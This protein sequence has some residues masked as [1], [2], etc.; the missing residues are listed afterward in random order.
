MKRSGS[1]G[2]RSRAGT[3]RRLPTTTARSRRAAGR[4]A[5]AI[6]QLGWPST[7]AARPRPLL[8]RGAGAGDARARSPALGSPE[9]EIEGRLYHAWAEALLERLRACSPDVDG[10]LMVGHNPGLHELAHCSRRP[11]PTRSRRARSRS[12]ASRSRLEGL[13]ARAARSS[14]LVVP[15]AARR[16]A[17]ACSACGARRARRPRRAARWRR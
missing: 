9:V 8:D 1:S 4:Q 6:R 10:V 16:L 5:S 2:T 13:R 7:R 11:A 17:R 12:C 3:T 15:R 14:Q